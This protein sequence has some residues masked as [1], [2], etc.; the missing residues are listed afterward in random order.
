MNQERVSES[1]GRAMSNS[2][3]YNGPLMRDS[4]LIPI[5]RERLE[6]SEINLTTADVLKYLTA[7]HIEKVFEY[8]RSH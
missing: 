3:N 1:V 8:D 4:R 6:D 7:G 5:D 2:L